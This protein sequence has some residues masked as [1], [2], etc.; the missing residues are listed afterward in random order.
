VI[1]S[2]LALFALSI[3]AI[4]ASRVSAQVAEPI[5]HLT[6]AVV[7]FESNTFQPQ[8][9]GAYNRAQNELGQL[10]R[11]FSA[12]ATSIID[13]LNLKDQFISAA[14]RFIPSQYLDLLEKDSIVDIKLGD[15]VRAEM[16]VMFSDLRGF[17]TLSEDM[18]PQQNF[19]YINEYLELVSPVIKQHDGFIVKFL[20]DGM[21]AVFPYGVDSAVLAGIEKLRVIQK[22][23]AALDHR[24][25][26]P[27]EIGIGI[28]T[29][30]MMVG[31]V[32]ESLRMQGDAFS[33]TVNLTSRVEGLNKYF[34][35][36][37]IITQETL[38][39][40]NTPIPYTLRYIGKVKVKGRDHPIELH[41]I[42][43]GLG[44]E[45]LNSRM[46]IKEDFELGLNAYVKGR[47]EIA[48]EHFFRVLQR[49]PEDPA[50]ILYSQ[51]VEQW[52][53]VEPPDHWDGVEEMTGK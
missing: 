23:N 14:A 41:E 2:L 9:L 19:D 12:M 39:R 22:Y 43:D 35:T 40:L 10:A 52:L 45:T 25:L 44:Q 3:L 16:A 49:T 17:S 33:D 51:R 21:M 26:P 18:T 11:A 53:G 5:L 27:I 46:A 15:H 38:L 24:G 42:C 1:T 30:H 31:F 36:S 6:N 13:A 47:F 29:G 34:G 48:R 20:G 37:M 7:S 28:H 4:L 32:G 8:Q 50:A